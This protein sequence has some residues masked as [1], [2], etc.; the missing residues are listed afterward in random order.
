M[1]VGLCEMFSAFIE[2]IFLILLILWIIL[3]DFQV[4]NEPCVL[5]IKH[6]KSLPTSDSHGVVSFYMLLNYSVEMG[7]LRFFFLDSM[8][9]VCIS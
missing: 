4:L 7:L 3:I 6:K 2:N 1:L 5:G 8:L 9:I